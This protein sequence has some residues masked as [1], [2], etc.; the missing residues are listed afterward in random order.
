MNTTTLTA[1]Q[2]VQRKRS[3]GS[4][5]IA[6]VVALYRPELAHLS[7]YRNATDV[8]MR[9][10]HGIE[11]PR[12]AAMGRGINVE[13]KLR[14]LY[15][16][17]VGPVDDPPGTLRHPAH[18]W[19]VGSPDGLAPDVL[20]E[21]KTA[22][23]FIRAQ[24]GEPGSDAVPDSYSLQVQW[25]MEIS[26]RKTAHV[27]VAFGNDF[28]GDDGVKDFAVTETAVYLVGFDVELVASMLDCGARFMAEHVDTGKAP[29]LKPLANIRKW[30]AL[31]KQQQST[32]GEANT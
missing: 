5:D 31:L 13:P 29:D 28:T 14:T 20:V 6:A 25:L 23:N 21:F 18:P 9:L 12:N 26:Q 10:V 15:R 4:T 11:Q 1:E 24:W 8:W 16:E 22:S 3:V 17:S 30:Q 2:Q 32:Q 19:A 7:K 27:L